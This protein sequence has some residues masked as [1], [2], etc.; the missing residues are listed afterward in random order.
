MEP[1]VTTTATVKSPLLSKT[2]ITAAL[3]LLFS[4]LSGTD[5]LSAGLDAPDAA[6]GVVAAG[7]VLVIFFR[8]ISKAVLRR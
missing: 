2:N 6:A 1:N 3:M 7:S 8:T 4:L 5:S